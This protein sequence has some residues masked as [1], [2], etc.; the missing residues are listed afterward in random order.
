MALDLPCEVCYH[1]HVLAA[2]AEGILPLVGIAYYVSPHATQVRCMKRRKDLS[3]H[4]LASLSDGVVVLDPAC[5]VMIF[6]PAMEEMTGTSSRR[7]TGMALA[8]LLPKGSPIPAR[9]LATLET[10]HPFFAPDAEWPRW[11]GQP[12]PTSLTIAS[13]L[14]R[15]G[16]TLGAVLVVRDLRRIKALEESQRPTERLTAF[17][18]LAA[19]MAHEIKNPL[20]GIRGA[21]QLLREELTTDDAREYTDV[22]IREADRL[23][24]LME[25]MLDF[26][27]PH[28]LTRTLVNLHEILD[29]VMAL[30]RP[31]CTVRGVQIRQHYDPSLPE[32]WADRNHLTQAFLNLTRNAWEAMPHGG[33]LTLTTR[34][35]SEP[36]R[37]G[38]GGGPMLM[39][40]LA[41]EGVGIPPE[42][43]R[44]LFTPF[45]TTKAKGSGLGLAISHR[46]I[47]EHG[48]RFVI[49]SLPGQGTTV[50]AYLPVNPAPSEGPLK[51][52]EIWPTNA[53]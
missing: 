28:P 2:A 40:E 36:I 26:A 1:G 7:V 52:E 18:V 33:T 50:R 43:Q 5:R 19:A 15:V 35:S 30:E 17:G 12:L 27:R 38:P 31:S 8:T 13:I 14:D 41:D 4:I 39:V 53:F 11:D 10:G 46:I 20:L 42:V 23:N 16:E 49:K 44:K 24:A 21:A 45:F 48:G 34:R 37:V 22:I 51:G 9:V 32:I 3:E 47:E 25:E 29:T 6:N